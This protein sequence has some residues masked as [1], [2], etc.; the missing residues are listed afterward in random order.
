L[1]GHTKAS[2]GGGDGTQ[3]IRDLR[4]LRALAHPLRLRI[5]ER[6]REQPR[7]TKQVAHLLGEPATR[8]YH[9]VHVLEEAGLIREH[10]TRQVRGATERYMEAISGRTWRES[11]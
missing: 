1:G 6:L 8:L 9:H 10:S 4:A 2:P 3:V 7:T 11:S 5:L